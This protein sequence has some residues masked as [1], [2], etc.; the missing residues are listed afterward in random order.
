MADIEKLYKMHY[1]FIFKYLMSLSHNEGVAEELTQETFFRAY[2]NI[3]KL[4]KEEKAAVWLC[5]I[6]KNLYF[7]WC[8]E[9]KRYQPMEEQTELTSSFDLSDT[10]EVKML[11]RQA[12]AVLNGLEE[13]YREVFQLAVLAEVS[14]KEISQLFGKSESWARVTLFR[15]KQKIIERMN[16]NG[17]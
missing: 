16:G 6:A 3:T 14:L 1:G 12:M 11:T 13:P 2:I 17:L 10:V 7:S 8:R 9:Q 5:Q 4:R 15:A